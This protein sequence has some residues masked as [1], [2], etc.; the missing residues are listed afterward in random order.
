MD[1][2]NDIPRADITTV[3]K[4]IISSIQEIWGLHADVL[5]KPVQH[6]KIPQHPNATDGKFYVMA[7]IYNMIKGMLQRG[8]SKNMVSFHFHNVNM[9]YD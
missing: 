1:Q 3:V 6:V 7:Y 4:A 2:P 9:S 8:S 5:E